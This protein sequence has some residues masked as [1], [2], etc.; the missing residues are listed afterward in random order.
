MA[1]LSVSAQKV[2][3]KNST[4]LSQ[5][6]EKDKKIVILDVR[7]PEEFAAGHLKGAINIDIRQQDFYYKIEKLNKKLTYFV[8]CR[9]N[10]RSGNAIEYMK[11][12]GFV[13]LYQMMDGFP[14]W[15]ANNLPIVK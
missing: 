12:K 6:L 1:L 5:I 4:E 2:I 9:T 10:H 11:Q 3:Q 13:T 8:Y 7:T 15:E 14:G